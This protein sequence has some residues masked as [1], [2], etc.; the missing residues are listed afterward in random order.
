MVAFLDAPKAL[1]DVPLSIP[2]INY[3]KMHFI[4]TCTLY[5]ADACLHLYKH[6]KQNI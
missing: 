4:L 2:K 1:E 5:R 6:F 3:Q